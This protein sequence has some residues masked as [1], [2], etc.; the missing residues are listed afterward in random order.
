MQTSSRTSGPPKRGST[1]ALQLV[2]MCLSPTLESEIE[3]LKL[4]DLNIR[5]VTLRS[6]HS[7]S[8]VIHMPSKTPTQATDA[9]LSATIQPSLQRHQRRAILISLL[10]LM[11]SPRSIET[12]QTAMPSPGCCPVSFCPQAIRRRC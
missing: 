7:M 1:T 4:R 6:K 8:V 5:I 3:T 10:P 12:A 2:M 9:M 11:A